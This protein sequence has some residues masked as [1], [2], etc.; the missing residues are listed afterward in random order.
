MK[1]IILGILS[2]PLQIMIILVFIVLIILIILKIKESILKK[3]ISS[4]KSS[5][6]L[7]LK[8]LNRIK[9]YSKTPKEKLDLLNILSKKIFREKYGLDEKLTYTDLSKKLRKKEQKRLS[10]F[11]EQMSIYYYSGEKLNDK[12]INNLIEDLIKIIMTINYNLEKV[13]K[14]KLELKPKIIKKN[15]LTEYDYLNTIQKNP[16][17]YTDLKKSFELINKQIQDLN[18]LI[19]ESYYN[20]D[21]KTKQKMKN[22]VNDYKTRLLEIAQKT[23]S[24]FERCIL[25]QKILEEHFKKI[26][27]LKK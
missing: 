16:R 9:R 23:D 15:N 3:E 1:D 12:K 6:T 18:N 2:S 19:K 27:L 17:T 13:D 25:Q 26:E 5:K 21:R 20:T 10:A 14:K 22:I 7:Y 8:E 11:S 24:P 4:Q